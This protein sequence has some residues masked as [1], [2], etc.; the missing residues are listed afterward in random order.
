MNW[1]NGEA[2]LD[3]RSCWIG[4]ELAFELVLYSILQ[5]PA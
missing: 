3:G 2:E 1:F 4:V 5:L